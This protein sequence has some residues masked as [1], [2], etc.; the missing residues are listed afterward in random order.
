MKQSGSD[1]RKRQEVGRGLRLCVNQN[2]ERMDTNVLGNDVHNINILTVIASESYDSFAKGLQ[3]EMAE[4]VADRPRAV[5][6]ELFVGKVIKDEHGNEQVIDQAT[7]SAIHF[8]MIV[9]T[10]VLNGYIDRKGAL[11]DKYYEDKA[12]GELKVA[13]E[14]AGSAASVLAIIDSIYDERSMQPENARSNNVELQ[15]DEDK[16]AMP[17]FKA[18]WSK[19]NAKSIYIVDFVRRN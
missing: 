3:T 14:V 4:A 15:V 10:A 12:N 8:D 13:E 2:G 17:E 19:I 9:S 16:L 6:V 5:T 18:L 11:T 7:A 1:V